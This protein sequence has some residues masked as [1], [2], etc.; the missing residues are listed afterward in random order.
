MA[1]FLS[2]WKT[3]AF[4]CLFFSSWAI[5]MPNVTWSTGMAASRNWIKYFLGNCWADTTLLIIISIPICIY[6]QWKG[7]LKCVPEINEFCTIV[8]QTWGW[9]PIT[10]RTR[11]SLF[12]FFFESF[13]MIFHLIDSNKCLLSVYMNGWIM[14]LFMLARVS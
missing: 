10:S 8:L 3:R 12:I 2:V 7:D 11:A 4:H 13:W 5:S 6:W 9:P 1:F 14:A